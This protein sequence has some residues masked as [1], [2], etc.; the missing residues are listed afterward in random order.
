MTRSRVN[1]GLPGERGV[2]KSLPKGKVGFLLVKSD[3]RETS[4]VL[5]DTRFM[6]DC[7]NMYQTLSEGE[8][9]D[10]NTTN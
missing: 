3:T 5:E 9:N 10:N 8:R 4:A 6:S 1:E 7:W 2:R